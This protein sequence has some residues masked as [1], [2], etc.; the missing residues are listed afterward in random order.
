MARLIGGKAFNAPLA[1]V[2]AI[3]SVD[4]MPTT[5]SLD[6]QYIALANLAFVKARFTGFQRRR[7]V[8]NTVHARSFE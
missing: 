2:M 5:P 1:V 8:V 3:G 7:E 4:A 6:D